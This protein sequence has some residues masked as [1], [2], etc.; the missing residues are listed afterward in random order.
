MKFVVPEED[1]LAIPGTLK[2]FHEGEDRPG[3]PGNPGEGERGLVLV[4]STSRGNLAVA[5]EPLATY[6]V[7]PFEKCP[8]ILG[9]L[10]KEFTFHL[11]RDPTTPSQYFI[12]RI[13][14][15]R[16]VEWAQGK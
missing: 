2:G 10:G 9:L 13:S 3:G 7:N 5:F 12:R 8:D 6:K 14:H 1:T 15:G 4:L 11:E 16:E